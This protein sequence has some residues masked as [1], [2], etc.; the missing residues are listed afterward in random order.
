MAEGKDA[1]MRE[2][3]DWVER[4]WTCRLGC[5]QGLGLNLFVQGHARSEHR[6][7]NEARRECVDGKRKRMESRGNES[8]VW[9]IEDDPRAHSG[10]GRDVCACV[11]EEDPSYSFGERRRWVWVRI[12]G[13]DPS[14]SFGKQRQ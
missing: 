7:Q 11:V 13:E 9:I 14:H 6:A 1:H 12:A 8:E 2:S 5:L 3:R 4:V 10:N